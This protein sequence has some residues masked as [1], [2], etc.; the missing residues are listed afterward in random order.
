VISRRSALRTRLTA[1]G[2]G[3]FY[4]LPQKTRLRLVR[5]ATPK[6]T[7][8]AVV[9]VFDPSGERLL[10]LRQPPGRGWTL[11]AGLLNRGE[12]PIQG[13]IREAAEE[14]GLRFTADDLE[15]AS[16]NAVVH[17]NGRW[18]D[19]VFRTHA[20]PETATLAVDGA[21]V[22]EAA[23]HDLA[24]LPKLTVATQRLLGVYGI[25]PDSP[26]GNGMNGARHG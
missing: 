10:L 23:W 20:D 22:W 16:P 1:V 8:G 18:V 9:L 25:G 14:T 19:T 26:N 4:R 7:I 17:T 5:L 24:D 21:E 15:P 11:P 12:T 2:Y 3:I 6:Y 13:A